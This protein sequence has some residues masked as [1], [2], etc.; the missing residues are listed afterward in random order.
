MKRSGDVTVAAVLSQAPTS[1]TAHEKK[2]LGGG[3]PSN[4]SFSMANGEFHLGR[5]LRTKKST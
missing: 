4:C 3:G 5:L 1:A 2:L